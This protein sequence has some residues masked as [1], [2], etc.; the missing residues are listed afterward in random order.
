MYQLSPGW[1]LCMGG[2]DEIT[3]PW[4]LLCARHIVPLKATKI[5]QAL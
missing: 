3:L 4:V 2:K 1:C 5:L